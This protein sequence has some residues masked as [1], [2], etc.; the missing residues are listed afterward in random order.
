LPT[1]EDGT[2]VRQRQAHH[3][4]EDR[5]LPRPVGAKKHDDLPGM[6]SQAHA[7]D[8][9]PP[10]IGLFESPRLKRVGPL[11][12]PRGTCAVCHWGLDC[13]TLMMTRHPSTMLRSSLRNM[14]ILVPVTR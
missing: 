8:D 9:A 6:Q 2:F 4:V 14:V 10:P 1:Q 5:R 12:V 13:L 7:H 3:Y 11:P